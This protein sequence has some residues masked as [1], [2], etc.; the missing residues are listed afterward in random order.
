MAQID[1]TTGRGVSVGSAYR[2]TSQTMYDKLMSENSKTNYYS[3][4][5][6]N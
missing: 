4:L 3:K 2:I 6:L 5:R 1:S